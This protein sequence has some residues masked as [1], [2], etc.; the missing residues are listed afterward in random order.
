MRWYRF[1]EW[2]F[3]LLG[4]VMSVVAL[5]F[6]AYCIIETTNAIRSEPARMACRSKQMDDERYTFTTTVVCVPFPT[7]QDTLSLREAK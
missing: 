2:L 5:A 1:E 7:R 3:D 4:I 6:L